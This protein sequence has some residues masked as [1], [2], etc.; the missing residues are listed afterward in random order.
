M[1]KV[2]LPLIVF[3]QERLG[4]DVSNDAIRSADRSAGDVLAGALDNNPVLGERPQGL[5]LD[6][7]K[8]DE[9]SA[10]AKDEKKR[11]MV[12]EDSVRYAGLKAEETML[13]NWE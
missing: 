1:F 8:L 6:G 13:V 10:E 4:F 9:I 7:A 5:Y 12:W 2:M 11:L 3:I